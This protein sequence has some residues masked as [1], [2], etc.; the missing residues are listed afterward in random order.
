MNLD[1]RQLGRLVLGLAAL[2]LC[3]LLA[4]SFLLQDRNIAVA[5]VLIQQFSVVAWALLILLSA[6]SFGAALLRW[7]KLRPAGNEAAA[8]FAVGLGLAVLSFLTL[9][10]GALGFMGKVRFVILLMALLFIGLQDLG[11]LLRSAAPAVRRMR[12]ASWFRIAL[13]CVLGF[14]LLLNLTRAFEPPWQYDVLE[15]HLAAPKAYH[16]A[17]RVFF[18]RDNV[19]ANFPENAEMLYLLSMGLTESPDRG[20][21]VGQLLGAAMGFLAALALRAMIAGVARKETADIAAAIF[22]VWPGVTLY[23]GMA[24]VELPLLFYGTLAIWGLVWSWRRK[25]TRPHARGW[26][27]LSAIAA[28]AA[29]GVKYTAALMLLAPILIWLPVLGRMARVAWGEILRRMACFTAV[30]VLCFSPWLIRNFVNT[31]NPVYPLLYNVF[32]GTNWDAQKD[33]RWTQAHSAKD[34]GLKN[35]CDLAREALF[36]DSDEGLPKASL[37]LFLFVPFAALAGRRIRWVVVL[38]AAHV[39]LLYLLWFMFTQQNVR[40][41]EAGVPVMAGLS[42]LGLDAILAGRFMSG[43]RPLVIL[44]LLFEPARWVNYLNVERSLPLALGAETE[45]QYF[46]GPMQV[47]FKIG[48]GAMQFIVDPE[49]VPPDAKIL[50]LGEARTFYCRRPCVAGTVFDTNRLEEIVRAAGTP[51]DIRDALKAEGITHIYVDTGELFRLQESYRYAFEGKERLGMLDR[52]NWDR[53]AA[54]AEKY[55]RPVKTFAGGRA[56]YFP[57]R[58]WEQEVK[59]YI[60][61]GGP[62][63]PPGGNIIALYELR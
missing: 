13:W 6:L 63:Y 1:R 55:L 59:R 46:R 14:F 18:L 56:E 62:K 37:V 9:C 36:V 38:F 28:G 3:A 23:S 57:W 61:A 47:D 53:F 48:Y 39:A 5:A 54:F 52:F 16:E 43:L 29:L 49:K 34:R 10:L 44:L 7:L 41:L 58:L 33:A 8:L 20:A 30:A 24:Y 11:A 50:F 21:L 4:K 42:A 25:L 40:F 45:D 51:E 27:A 22:Y 19:Y 12:R 26:V 31:R 17:G 35:F 2:G 32:G 15:Y 60:A